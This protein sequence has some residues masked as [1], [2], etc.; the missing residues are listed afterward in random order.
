MKLQKNTLNIV[1]L[2][3]N[4]LTKS[5]DIMSLAEQALQNGELEKMYV[6]NKTLQLKAVISEDYRGTESSAKKN[7]RSAILFVEDKVENSQVMKK[8]K[9]GEIVLG[10]TLSI[11]DSTKVELSKLTNTSPQR[12]IL[13]MYKTG[14]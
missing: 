4:E 8:I 2:A 5:A 3:D 6:G 13:S 12:I 11:V 1:T 9:Q 7:Q 10:F 14:A